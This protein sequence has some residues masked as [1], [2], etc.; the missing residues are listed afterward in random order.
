MKCWHVN[1]DPLTILKPARIERVFV[2]P[3]IFIIRDVISDSE[4]KHIKM[5]ATPRVSSQM[6]SI[7]LC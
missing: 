7:L 4:I 5:L 3:E 6:I 1:N 2:N